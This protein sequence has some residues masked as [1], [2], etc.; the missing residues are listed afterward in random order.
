M[1]ARPGHEDEPWNQ[2]EQAERAK[3]EEEGAPSEASD[4]HAAEQE[5]KARAEK[6]AGAE[7]GICEAALIF[8]EVEGED[9]SVGRIG[10]GLAE[11]EKQAKREEKKEGVSD[12]G[13]GG[14]DGPK[15]EAGCENEID[16]ETVDEP[17]G[18]ELGEA[19]GPEKSGEEKSE[20]GVREREFGLQKW[21]GDSEIAAI[22]VV[23]E[24][25][26]GQED[27]RDEEASRDAGS[28]GGHV[29]GNMISQG[30]REMQGKRAAGSTFTG[31]D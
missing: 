17:A 28:L 8:G 4:E 13:E 19:V 24:D 22:D 31:I 29:S 12:A 27:E 20:A 5:T 15:R 6:Q 14:S 1:G 21:S 25:G 30:S 3:G 16:V 2:P 11:T 23:D 9:F 10:D 7:N 18:E 26:G